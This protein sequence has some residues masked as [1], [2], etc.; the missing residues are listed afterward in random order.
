M[1]DRTAIIIQAVANSPHDAIQI[2]LSMATDLSNTPGISDKLRGRRTVVIETPDGY[3]TTFEP[4]QKLEEIECPDDKTT[5]VDPEESCPSFERARLKDSTVMQ[6]LHSGRSLKQIVGVLSEQ[7]TRC[8]ERIMELEAIAPRKIIL[9]D[10]TIFVWRCP[11]EM[12]PS[13]N[14]S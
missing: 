9:P 13:D 5:V 11:T 1:S 8:V 14:P 2:L 7:K 4:I 10:G 6:M 3:A 12:L